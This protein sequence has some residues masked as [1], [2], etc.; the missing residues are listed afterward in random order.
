M[1]PIEY[2]LL[3]NQ[4]ADLSKG[5]LGHLLHIEDDPADARLLVE[6][7]RSQ[8]WPDG[9]C[10]PNRI[11]QVE[12]L[13]SARAVLEERDVSG[14]LCDL[15][16][17]DSNGLATC[18]SLLDDYPHIPVTVIT[19]DT[20]P[21]L[22]VEAL[23]IGALD[24]LI[25]EE[26]SPAVLW[27]S[28]SHGLE[29]CRVRD[30]LAQAL[31]DK[32]AA[33]RTAERRRDQAERAGRVKAD[34]LAM[35]S[36]D[37]RTPL[38][39]II[40]LASGLERDL[41]N[42]GDREIARA[43]ADQGV[44][45]LGI[46]SGILEVLDNDG[47]SGDNAGGK[48][49]GGAKSSRKSVFGAPVVTGAAGGHQMSCALA[50]RP[51]HAKAFQP[52]PHPQPVPELQPELQLDLQTITHGAADRTC[53]PPRLLVVEDMPINRQVIEAI[54]KPTNL[55]LDFAPD[56]WSALSRARETAYD[57][58]LMDIQLPGIDGV[59][60]TKRIRQ[61]AAMNARTPVVAVT[62]QGL[63]SDRDAYLAAGLD[64]Y[65]A[66]PL[67]PKALLGAVSRYLPLSDGPAGGHPEDS[68]TTTT[69]SVIPEQGCEGLV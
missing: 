20:T 43:I 10:R 22:G 25:K 44:E 48:G 45:L 36:H 47:I 3:E 17:P 7:F 13:R 16:L 57:L 26:L 1:Y 30:A 66:K 65:V 19:G 39:G 61:S 46:L 34:F 55:D 8:E 58:I 35:M 33:Q 11:I 24:F 32:E 60:T 5:G 49:A 29:R 27:R 40:G 21:H 59:E 67:T 53:R 38:N 4:S 69:G 51:I 12:S 9:A 41:G 15:N 64:D 28:L 31:T 2:T 50:N 63:A 68:S 14:I 56:G 23:R 18:T 54:L 37:L 62:A 52:H 6:M 42:N